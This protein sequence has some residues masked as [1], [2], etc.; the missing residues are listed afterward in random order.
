MTERPRETTGR[1]PLT[2][3]NVYAG[4][5]FATYKEFCEELGLE[6]KTGGAKQN[7]MKD[8]GKILK[9]SSRGWKIIIEEIRDGEELKEIERLIAY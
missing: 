8:L 4:R 7:Q 6:I 5:E 1:L 2:L 9:I 3:S